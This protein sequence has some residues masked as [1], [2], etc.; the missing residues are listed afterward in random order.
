MFCLCYGL[1]REDTPRND[2]YAEDDDY[3]KLTGWKLDASLTSKNDESMLYQSARMMAE[4]YTSGKDVYNSQNINSKPQL[5][6]IKEENT[7][8]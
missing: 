5:Q 3:R 4:R 1:T 2:E 7:A 6:I 8:A